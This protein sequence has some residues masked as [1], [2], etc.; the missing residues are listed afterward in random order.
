MEILLKIFR[1]SGLF[2]R[3]VAAVA[4]LK[5]KIPDPALIVNLITLQDI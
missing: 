4:D 5:R 2:S 1:R 3:L